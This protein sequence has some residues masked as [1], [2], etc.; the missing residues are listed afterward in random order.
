MNRYKANPRKTVTFRLILDV[1]FDPQGTHPDD[2]RRNLHQVVRDAVNNG[3]LTGET[4]ATVETWD[5]VIECRKEFK[6]I[7]AGQTYT[8]GS[9]LK[10]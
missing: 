4:P 9:H 6:T 7:Q 8:V 2:L 3:T 5:C 1:E 10:A